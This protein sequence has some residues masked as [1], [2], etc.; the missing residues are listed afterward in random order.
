MSHSPSDAARRSMP[1]HT[2]AHE[3]DGTNPLQALAQ[4]GQSIWLDDLQRSAFTSGEFKRLI[5]EDGLRGVT[6]NP[7]IFERALAHDPEYIDAAVRIAERDRLPPMALYEALAIQDIRDAADL[8]RP[9]YESTARADGYASV[10]VSPYVAYDTRATVEE[11]RRLWR[12][13]G[14][15]NAMIKVPASREGPSAVRQ[16]TAEG[17]NVNIT[18]LF[19]L[20]RYEDVAHAYTDGLAEF[21]AGGGDPARVASVASFFVSRID[22]RIDGTIAKRLDETRDPGARV[23]LESLVGRVA[24]ANAKRAYQR[25]L[26]MSRA[27]SWEALA[28][29][30]AHPQRLLWA[31]T[32]T[33]NPRYR[34][35]RYVEE[36]IGA[37]T[38]TTLT[39]ATIE[40]YRDHGEVRATLEEHVEDA[41]RVL[42]TLERAGISLLA[43]TDTLLDDGV[44]AFCKSLD[45]ILAALQGIAGASAPVTS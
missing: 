7:S 10:E 17:I 19:G 37:N 4:L 15:D 18:L 22:T 41:Y 6:S 40:A 21:V 23:R 31:S 36:L 25:Y 2:R 32:G 8:L 42:E 44:A 39:P 26:A 38:V 43:A 3:R 30:G 20:E 16:L 5:V 11:A 28:A 24:V 9:V 14:R 12:A 29:K 35:V 13:I 45:T 1:K 33:K 27:P 34:D